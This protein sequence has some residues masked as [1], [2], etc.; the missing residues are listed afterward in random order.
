MWPVVLGLMA[1]MLVCAVALGFMLR[2]RPIGDGPLQWDV[3]ETEPFEGPLHASSMI[4]HEGSGIPEG[5]SAEAYHEWLNGTMPDGW[6]DAQW[7]EFTKEQLQ[8]FEYDASDVEK[9]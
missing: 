9:D 8:F 5:W 2:R 7:I 3:E 4:L 6:S 1:L